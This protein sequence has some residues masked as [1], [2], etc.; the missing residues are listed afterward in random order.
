MPRETNLRF[1]VLA[2]AY[3]L[4]FALIIKLPTLKYPVSNWDELI[5]LEL[6]RHWL[7]T[8]SYSLAGSDLLNR[9][10]RSFYDHPVFHHPPGFSVLLAPFVLTKSDQLAVTLS[11][12][13]HALS[14][15]SVALVGY[16]LLLH[17]KPPDFRNRCVFLLPLA[18]AAADPLM[19]FIARKIWMDNLLAGTTSLA[20]C[21]AWLG[22]RKERWRSWLLATAGM[23]AFACSLK[24]TAAIVLPFVAWLAIPEDRRQPVVRL[25]IVL[26]PGILVLGAWF[27]YF[28][29]R[30]GVWLPYWMRPDE[31]FLKAN[32]FVAASATQSVPSYLLKVFA[33]M[34]FFVVFLLSIPFCRVPFHSKLE[35]VSSTW[36]FSLLAL[37]ALLGSAGF[38]KEARYLAPVIPVVCWLLY[39]RYEDETQELAARN[40]QFFPLFFL[41]TLAGGML[42]GYYLLVPQYDEILSPVDLLTLIFAGKT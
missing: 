40:N 9:L 31:D 29:E 24:V 8:G 5:Y 19:N 36:I 13:G 7:A 10:P 6:S 32:P 23:A 39:A 27:V 1:A 12:L 14:L 38:A 30:T 42:A 20:L 15:A 4:A 28:H 35:K 17:N 21:L 26:L 34:P 41:A 16:E 3:F 18:A 37:F 22:G 25:L 2:S 33:C 11:W